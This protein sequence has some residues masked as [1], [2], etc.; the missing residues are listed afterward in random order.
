MFLSCALL[1][2]HCHY[3]YYS[4]YTEREGEGVHTEGDLARVCCDRVGCASHGGTPNICAHQSFIYR[5]QLSRFCCLFACCCDFPYIG[6]W[7]SLP[8]S[9][10]GFVGALGFP[11]IGFRVVLA[12]KRSAA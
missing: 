11:L 1:L 7:A 3:M 8:C 5:A 10:F 2:G 12:P 4:V 9:M 6:V